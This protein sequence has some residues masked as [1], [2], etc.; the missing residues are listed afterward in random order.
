MSLPQIRE[1][2]GDCIKLCW[3]LL[4]N[5]QCTDGAM[6]MHTVTMKPKIMMAAC[7]V[8]WINCLMN[9]IFTHRTCVLLFFYKLAPSHILNF[10]ILYP[11]YYRIIRAALCCQCIRHCRSCVL[12]WQ[13]RNQWNILLDFQHFVTSL[14][15]T[16]WWFFV[17]KCELSVGIS[18]YHKYSTWY[19]YSQIYIIH[20]AKF[21]TTM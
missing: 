21:S 16:R 12:A 6:R 9:V 2:P 1:G 3:S 11:Q 7:I 15:C 10:R 17:R 13:P 14:L 8:N 18:W 4:H 5:P 19:W 20:N